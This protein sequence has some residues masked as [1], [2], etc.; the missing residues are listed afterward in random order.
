MGI[1]NNAEKAVEY[2]QQHINVVWQ[3]YA[4]HLFRPKS[5]LYIFLQAHHLLPRLVATICSFLNSNCFLHYIHTYDTEIQNHKYTSI[6]Q[7]I[8]IDLPVQTL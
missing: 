1:S 2:Y 7:G 8:L 3:E 4:Y 6:W 5:F